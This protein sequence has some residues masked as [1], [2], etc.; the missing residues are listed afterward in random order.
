MW[1]LVAIALTAAIAKMPDPFDS[2]V[3]LVVSA[4]HGWGVHAT[5]LWVAGLLV[6]PAF[7][8][9]VWCWS[10]AQRRSR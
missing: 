7:A 3:L 6:V 9:D 5:D 8:W 4:E 2:P 1:T 10:T